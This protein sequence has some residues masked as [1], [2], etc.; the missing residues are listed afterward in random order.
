M[1]RRIIGNDTRIRKKTGSTCNQIL[2]PTNP[3]IQSGVRT[4]KSQPATALLNEIRET[5]LSTNE[6]GEIKK[7][8][9]KVREI[10]PADW[11]RNGFDCE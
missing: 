1:S 9:K 5:V 7:V 8:I 3:K 6:K 10:Y 11:I 4:G 2:F